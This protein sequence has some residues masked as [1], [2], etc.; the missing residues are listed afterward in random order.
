MLKKKLIENEKIH[1]QICICQIGWRL[2]VCVESVYTEKEYNHLLQVDNILQK[3]RQNI[4]MAFS[5]FEGSEN[6]RN[7]FKC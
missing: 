2:S 4:M 7:S 1:L 6:M 3:I 5:V